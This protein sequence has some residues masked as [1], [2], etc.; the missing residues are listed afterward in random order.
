MKLN[1]SN[2]DKLRKLLEHIGYNVRLEKGNFL[3]GECVLEHNN[4]I[5]I[6][7]F[8]PVE[9][10]VSM[11][12]DIVQQIGSV[13]DTLGDSDKRLYDKLKTLKTKATPEPNSEPTN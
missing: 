1:K 2:R 8:S 5:V 10:Q 11:L 7:K 6:N 13:P 9:A 12:I 4:Y 3:G